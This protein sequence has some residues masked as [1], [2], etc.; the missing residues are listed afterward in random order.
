MS[1]KRKTV[2]SLLGSIFMV[3]CLVVSADPGENSL[4]KELEGKV[5]TGVNRKLDR[6]LW[7]FDL[8][9]TV[10]F[11]ALFGHNADGGEPFRLTENT[12]GSTIV[13]TNV[14]FEFKNLFG[15]TNDAFKADDINLPLRRVKVNVDFAGEIR[16]SL[17]GH[18]EADQLEP[19]VAVPSEPI[20]LEQWLKATGE[21]TVRCDD[22]GN[23]TIT[24]HHEGLIP[25]GLYTVVASFDQ[26]QLHPAIPLGGVPNIFVADTNGKGSYSRKINFCPMNLKEGELPLIL[27]TT[28]Y[29]SDHQVYGNVPLLLAKGIF[30]GLQGHEQVQ[31]LVTGKECEVDCSVISQ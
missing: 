24:L 15:V 14:D 6:K 25:L 27:I 4:F 19:S 8:L 16:Q 26:E 9:G 10:G 17:R 7:E 11:T 22:E 2:N 29:H 18:L 20:T 13:A 30:P 28:L 23:S 12:P 21:G 3:S 31:F 5:V 1:L